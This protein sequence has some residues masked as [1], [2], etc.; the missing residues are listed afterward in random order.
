MEEITFEDVLTHYQLK[1]REAAEEIEGARNLLKKGGA[2]LDYGWKGEAADALRIKLEEITSEL[3]KALS[4]ISEA[5]IKLSAISEEL[6]AQEE[7]IQE[8]I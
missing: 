5:Q 3:V 4:N 1:L 2:E 8:L 6:E 7:E